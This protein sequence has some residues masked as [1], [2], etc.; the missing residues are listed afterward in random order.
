MFSRQLSS[1]FSTVA[2]ILACGLV[3]SNGA[4]AQGADPDPIVVR[5]AAVTAGMGSLKDVPIPEVPNLTDFVA[6]ETAL[7]QLGKAL[8]WDMQV[9]SDGQACASCHFAAGADPRSKNQLNPGINAGDNSF[10]SAGFPE[11]GPNYDLT[12]DDFP[13]HDLAESEDR[14]STVLRDTNDVVSSMGVF[15][16][17]IKRVKR[18]GKPDDIGTALPDNIFNNGGVNVRRV[19]PRNTPT[20]FNSVFNHSNFWDGR[21]H[22]QFNGASVFGPLDDKAYILSADSDGNLSNVKLMLENSSLASQA[23]GPPESNFEMSFN[24]RSLAMIGQKLMERRPLR[25][26]LVHPNDSVLS[27]L[28]S[29]KV[30]RAGRVTGRKGLRT[31]YATLVKA[32]FYSTYW[33]SADKLEM[34]DS[35]QWVAYDGR[36]RGGFTQI[37]ANFGLFFGLSVQAY[38][39]TLVADDTPFDQFMGDKVNDPVDDALNAEQLEGLLA[40]IGE[41]NCASCH[42]GPEL[43][44]A[45]FTNLIEIEDGEVELELIEVEETP[46]LDEN[47]EFFVGDETTFL[48]N[49]FSNIGVR[50]NA[51]DLGRGGFGPNGI[52]LSFSRQALAGKPF[53]PELPDYCGA[54][55]QE[56]CPYASRVSVDGAFKVP[57]LRNVELTGP[58]FHNGGTLTLEQVVEFYD[59]QGDFSEEN[60]A[61]LDRQIALIEI[62]EDDEE[63]LVEFLLALTDERVRLEQA[64][65][66]HPQL[67]VPNGHPGDHFVVDCVETQKNGTLQACDDLL[68]IPALGAGGRPAAGLEPLGTFL[69]VEH[70]DDDDDD[71]T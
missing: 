3:L 53:A 61:E 16:A 26:Q 70:L 39:T 36:R 12:E 46:E 8:F 41:A 19:E 59:R 65:F 9:G 67:F 63:P 30:N 32:A 21:A 48:D 43:T 5:A 57:G 71:D 28:T 56:V 58:Y 17:E 62:D 29:T 47:G 2:S 1:R 13:F 60:L 69:D 38:E 22:N 11:F 18:R 31:T 25:N 10:G 49:G 27:R 55:D 44:D 6:N 40:F 15:N 68:E 37:E 52:P 45:A 66:D 64:P 4:T 51:E 33:D 23:V 34:D 35:G 20:V 42:G 50:V 24:Q 54:I 7:V 14:N